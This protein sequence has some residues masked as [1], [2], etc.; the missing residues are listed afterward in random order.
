M[1]I[2]WCDNFDREN[3]DERIVAENIQ[4]KRD[5]ELMLNALLA[6]VHDRSEHTYKLVADDYVLWKFKP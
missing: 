2:V 6:T 1:K 4:N 5:A 3:M